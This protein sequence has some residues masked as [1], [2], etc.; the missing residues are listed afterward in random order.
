M[1]TLWIMSLV[2]FFSFCSCTLFTPS[3]ITVKNRSCFSIVVET[4]RQGGE[5][6]TIGRSKNGHLEVY[7]GALILKITADGGVGCYE[8]H[9]QIGYLENVEIVYTIIQ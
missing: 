7:P 4:N 2:S 6:V 5:P 8:H 1:K 9:L 3:V